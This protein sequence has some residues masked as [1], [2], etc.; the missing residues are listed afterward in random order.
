MRFF[1]LTVA[2][3][4]VTGALGTAGP[5]PLEAGHLACGAEE[6]PE[7]SESPLKLG[8]ERAA[9]GEEG[10]IKELV[11]LQVAIMK[12]TGPTKRGQHPKHHG[13]VEAGFAVR[14]DIPEEYR[15]GLFSEPRSYKAKVRFSN[16]A[17]SDDSVPDVHGMA[18]KVLGVEGPRALE[19]AGREE[20]DF[21]LMDSEV[22]FAPDAKT[23]LGL[24]KARVAS[25]A[26]PAV[27]EEF[28]TSNP[29]TAALLAAS[30]KTIPSPLVVSYWST[31]PFKLGDRAVKYAVMPADGDVPGDVKPVGA[32][33]LRR[34][35]VERLAE[36]REPVTFD[37]CVIPQTD[38]V[39]MPVE[40]STVRWESDPIPV[41][42]ITVGPQSFDSPER[43]KECE[44]M[45]FDPWHALDEHRPLGGLNRARKAV[46][47]ASVEVRRGGTGG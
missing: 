4:I 28:N 14:D 13:C 31:V 16:G 44:E 11:A 18:V 3:L 12:R 20:Q 35:M 37:L 45:V 38:P 25:A 30:R 41:A 1:S 47:P 19:G 33:Y 23:V 8:E 26:R 34:A 17:S 2:A 5:Y 15:L 22:F 7:D 42:R 46:Y 21:V 10:V 9:A 43:M 39:R 29:R 6:P 24:M 27:L 40:D 32:D 36:G